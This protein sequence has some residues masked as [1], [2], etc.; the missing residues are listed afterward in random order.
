MS[1]WAVA[2]CL[3][4]SESLADRVAAIFPTEAEEAWLA[5]GWRLDLG[6]A[7]READRSGKPLFLWVMNGHP[8][9]CT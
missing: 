5:P 7:R 6:A 9:G 8:F 4:A 2:L 1:A 3:L